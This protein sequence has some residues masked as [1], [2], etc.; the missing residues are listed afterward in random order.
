[1]E[2]AALD[3]VALHRDFLC[4]ALPLHLR[5]QAVTG[6]AGERIRLVEAHV[7]DGVG[8][9]HLLEPGKSE[10]EPLVIHL[11][12]VQRR[13][14]ALAAHHAPSVGQPQVGPL[15]SVLA[16]KR[17]ELG[18]VHRSGGQ[19]EGPDEGL[20]P[21]SFVVEGEAVPGVSHRTHSRLVGM[22]VR[23]L[24]C[25]HVGRNGAVP[26]RGA[27]RIERE[28]VLDVHEEQLLVL[29]LVLQ[30]DLQDRGGRV[31][32][33]QGASSQEFLHVSVHVAAVVENLLQARSG[34][35]AARRPGV[36]L[37]HGLVVGIEQDTKLRMRVPVAGQLVFQQEGL[38][39]PAG[40]RQ[41]PLGGAGE[42][43]GLERAVL[44]RQG[45]AQRFGGLADGAVTL[46][47]G[48][49]GHDIAGAVSALLVLIG[50]RHGDPQDHVDQDAG[51]GGGAQGKHHVGDAHHGGIPPQALGNAAA[52]ASDPAVP[53]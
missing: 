48:R 34:E 37:S 17:Q 43:H 7:T 12:P 28:Q 1:M 42:L 19:P 45:S 49:V 31:R 2:A 25:R 13:L 27:Q 5:G 51:E 50:L 21:G 46:C 30:P 9:A 38:E 29:L 16:Q 6:P 44:R 3:E 14:P 20:V 15:V 39:E 22:P 26:I 8:G 52:N 24:A 23:A 40:V 35:E 32:R 53:A 41:V 18:V 47:G 36:L 33:V 10:V 11:F 4:R